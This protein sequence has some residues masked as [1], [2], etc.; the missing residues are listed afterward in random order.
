M[1]LDWTRVKKQNIYDSIYISDSSDNESNNKERIS[2]KCKNTE[3]YCKRAPSKIFCRKY[4][5]NR[6]IKNNNIII[7]EDIINIEKK[8]KL[9]TIDYNTYGKKSIIN[10]N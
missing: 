7:N 6:V 8:I 2:L 9:M 3:K 5:R 10:N 1:N 4:Y